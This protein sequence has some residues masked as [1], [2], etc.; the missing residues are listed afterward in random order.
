[1]C[2]YDYE[3][4]SVFTSKFV[5]AR[6]PRTCC[7]CGNPIAIGDRHVHIKMLVDGE[8]S[9]SRQC[10]SC[11]ALGGKFL[12]VSG[13]SGYAVG[14]LFKDIVEHDLSVAELRGAP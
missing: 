7:E 8:W 11:D 2:N 13:C 6:K 14:Y 9:E 1:M 12:A 10:V 3:V 5:T 4:A